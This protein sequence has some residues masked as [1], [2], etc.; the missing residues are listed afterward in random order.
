MLRTHGPIYRSAWTGLTGSRSGKPQLP[1]MEN[2]GV[3]RC[4]DRT[5]SHGQPKHAILPMI[6]IMIMKCFDCYIAS[7]GASMDVGSGFETTA[8]VLPGDLG[9]RSGLSNHV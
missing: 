1:S 7:S 4:R 3:N 2:M 9:R 5:P 8:V 6:T